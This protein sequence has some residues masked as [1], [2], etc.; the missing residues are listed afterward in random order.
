MRAGVQRYQVP[1][2]LSHNH[3][4]SKKLLPIPVPIATSTPKKLPHRAGRGQNPKYDSDFHDFLDPIDYDLVPRPIE[5]K[6]LEGHIVEYVTIPPNSLVHRCQGC[7][8]EITHQKYFQP[9]MNLLFRYKMFHKFPHPKKPGSG[10][11]TLFTRM[12]ISIPMICVAL[13]IMMSLGI[14]ESKMCTCQTE[15]FYI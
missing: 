2:K 5:V 15:C 14:Y 9:P 7:N 8:R 3:S 13:G 10:L 12:D 11:M 6:K 4:P 1:H